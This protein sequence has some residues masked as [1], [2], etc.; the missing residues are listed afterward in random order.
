M[1]TQTI[2]RIHLDALFSLGGI[3]I[4]DAAGRPLAVGRRTTP[5]ERF[6]ASA[7]AAYALYRQVGS[8]E[9][10]AAALTLALAG[11]AKGALL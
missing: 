7:D 11:T 2:T 1:T 5:G 9:E 4:L 10:T 6:L 3:L 8:V